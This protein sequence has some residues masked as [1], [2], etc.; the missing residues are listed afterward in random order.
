MQGSLARYLYLEDTKYA[1]SV[2]NLNKFRF[3][4]LA[5]YFV[6]YPLDENMDMLQ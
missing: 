2:I 6:C 4:T 5:R 3:A 1:R